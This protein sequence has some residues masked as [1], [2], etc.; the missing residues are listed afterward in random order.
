MTGLA[1]LCLAGSLGI[2]LLML[3]AAREAGWRR[4][5]IGMLV[6]PWL[7]AILILLTI[8]L[9]AEA[10]DGAAGLDRIGWTLS[11]TWLVVSLAMH[12][13][14][15]GGGDPARLWG[16]RIAHAG[17][18]VA[19]GGLLLSSVFTSTITRALSPG[20]TVRFANW[21]V[22]LHDIWPAAGEGWAGVAAEL[23]VSGGDGVISLTP[24][25][26]SSFSGATDAQTATIDSGTGILIA[27]LGPRNAEGRWQ[28]DLAWTPLLVLIP[29][30]LTVT[31][32][33]LALAMAG[34]GFRRW[35]R[36]RRARLAKAWWA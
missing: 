4:R 24:E 13:I 35:R 16:A 17:V 3:L 6:R 7:L 15:R 11:G 21:T 33:G 2:A 12:L 31:I 22:Q 18:A 14:G 28:L 29:I 23:R 30:G 9:A 20:E 8:G 1:A 25:L 36:L 34:P 19:I 5:R 10:G 32:A 26:R 27:R